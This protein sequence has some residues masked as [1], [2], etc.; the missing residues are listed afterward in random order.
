MASN[1]P[2]NP[3]LLRIFTPV[4][5]LNRD[6][7]PRYIEGKLT[8]LEK[9]LVE[10]HLVD[11]DLCNEA[12][13]ILENDTHR[14][15]YNTLVTQL[16]QYIRINIKPASQVK[17]KETAI[18][19]ERNRESMLAIFWMI[20]FIL[21]IAGG[22]YVYNGFQ[23]EQLQTAGL[24]PDRSSTAIPANT[25]TDLQHPSARH[26]DTI[27]Q[28]GA[29]P[30]L[31]SVTTQANAMQPSTPARHTDSVRKA[32]IPLAIPQHKDSASAPIKKTTDSTA[33]APLLTKA[34]DSSKKITDD[35]KE[36]DKKP[37]PKKPEPKK[38]EPKKEEPKK[39]ETT[40]PEATKK[41][42]DTPPSN[43]LDE[44]MYKAAR[45]SQQ[46]GDLNEAIARYKNIVNSSSPKYVELA[47]YQIAQCYKAQGH[48][49]KAKRMFKEVIKMNGSM[50]T[51]AQQAIDSDKSDAD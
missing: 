12:L 30:I 3:K 24:P 41:K 27:A 43:S 28:A 42:D 4:R 37:E 25:A 19:K 10:Q 17:K 1:V 21:L 34:P 23:R 9:H 29:T 32:A 39:N 11:C 2:A 46:D 44:F 22:I 20:A 31:A 16:Q 8:D 13:R 36:E 51:Q 49:S 5:C 6:Q 35:K 48:H 50:K 40:K 47:T 26:S 15:R 7:M 33:K 38:E 18:R 14:G 45:V